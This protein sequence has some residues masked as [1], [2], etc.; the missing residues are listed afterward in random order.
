MP[1]WPRTGRVEYQNVTI[2]YD[3]NG[4]DILK[5][6]NL[7]FEPGKR[8]AIVGRTGSGKSTVCSPTLYH[9]FCQLVF[10]FH[11]SN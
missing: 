1:H 3:A 8:I 6:I 11:N 9:I 2:R 4:P 5:N 7:I 10:F